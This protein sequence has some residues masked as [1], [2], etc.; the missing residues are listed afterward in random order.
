MN[1]D[2]VP[3]AVRGVFAVGFCPPLRS[4]VEGVL[5]E[6]RLRGVKGPPSVSLREP[7]PPLGGART[8]GLVTGFGDR[9]VHA[10]PCFHCEM[11]LQTYQGTLHS[12]PL[13]RLQERRAV[14]K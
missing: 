14:V 8:S 4:G 5:Q 11:L 13:T 10:K 3:Y 1:E 9:S 2:F 12:L 7:P 6:A